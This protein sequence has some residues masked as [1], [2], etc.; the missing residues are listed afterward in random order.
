[1]STHAL[2][3]RLRK[4]DAA[5]A[6]RV[7]AHAYALGDLLFERLDAS[8]AHEWR[9]DGIVEPP[10]P[11]KSLFSS[12]PPPGPPKRRIRWEAGVTKELAAA[13]SEFLPDTTTPKHVVRAFMDEYMGHVVA[14]MTARMAMPDY[15]MTYERTIVERAAYGSNA[16][17]VTRTDIVVSFE[18][19]IVAEGQ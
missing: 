2:S 5:H 9:F 12:P 4:E 11:A 8:A 19:P 1:M 3:E 13:K 17:D 18:Y 6:A 10:A 15:R 14:R 7:K 16:V